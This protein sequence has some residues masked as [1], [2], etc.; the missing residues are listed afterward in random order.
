MN[1]RNTLIVSALAAIGAS[2]CCVGPLV[3]LSLGIGGAWIATVTQLEPLRPVFIGLTLVLLF[4]A[5]RKLHRAPACAPGQAC[6]HPAVARR[7][8]TVFWLVA[9]LLVGLIASPWIVPYFT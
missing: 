3:L 4:L 8:K 7:Q 6:S 5:W 1:A 9:P 2:A